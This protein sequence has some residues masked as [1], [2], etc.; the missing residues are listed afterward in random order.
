MNDQ[1]FSKLQNFR[2]SVNNAT[3]ERPVCI[4]GLL[5]CLISQQNAFL[6]GPP[7]TGKSD[8]VRQIAGGI[9]NANHFQYLLTPTTEPTEI[10]GPVRV[11]ELLE[12]KYTRDTE[13][14][15]PTAH[16]VFLDELFRGSSAILNNLLTLLNERLFH[17]GKEKVETPIQSIIAATNSWPDEESLQAFADRFLWRPTVEPLKKPT[18][19]NILDQW[20]FGLEPRPKV[21]QH[22]TLDDLTE[23]QNEARQ[24]QPSE[25]FCTEFS[26][27]I[28]M[29]ASR[30]IS[31]SDRRRSQICRFLQALSLIHI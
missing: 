16:V 27:V 2:G 24:I 11:T 15:L 25:N 17:N 21:G 4:D 6:L 14:Y 10:F 20:S 19:K 5:A 28:D 26:S 22:L 23:L 8:L 9:V 1:L 29:L 18:S 7:G 30:G 3:L 13:G 12:D 31:V